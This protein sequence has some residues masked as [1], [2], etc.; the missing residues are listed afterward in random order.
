MNAAIWICI[1]CSCIIAVCFIVA[2]SFSIAKKE[3]KENS[4]SR[5]PPL[6]SKP[7]SDIEIISSDIKIPISD[8][9]IINKKID[10][11]NKTIEYKITLKGGEIKWYSEL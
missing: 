2:G 10:Y 8:I 6:C 9:E 7:I 4:Q 3:E 5:E 1:G 11:Q